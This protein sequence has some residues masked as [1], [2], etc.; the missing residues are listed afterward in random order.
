[1][2]RKKRGSW[3]GARPKCPCLDCGRPTID[4]DYY[5]VTMR[6]WV[7][8]GMTPTNEP[9]RSHQEFLCIACLETRLGREL[10][11]AD[12][13]DV[14]LNARCP[15]PGELDTLLGARLQPDGTSD[16]LSPV[17]WLVS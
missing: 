11:R 1:M 2:P 4:T 16:G 7:Q 5:M 13:A 9:C 8:A 12:F 14:P 3:R 10:V 6:V 15:S 17:D